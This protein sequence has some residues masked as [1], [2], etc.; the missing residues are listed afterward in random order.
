VGTLNAPFQSPKTKWQ[1]VASKPAQRG[2]AKGTTVWYYQ[3]LQM[4]E[5]AA[6]EA[7]IAAHGGHWRQRDVIGVS[8]Y[9]IK[10]Q[11][12][13]V[14]DIIIMLEA[15]KTAM[16]RRMPRYRGSCGA[17]TD[18]YRRTLKVAVAAANAAT[19]MLWETMQSR[20]RDVAHD[21]VAEFSQMWEMQSRTGD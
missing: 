3:S 6:T 21:A 15:M 16:F 11:G 18:N 12:F 13:N 17:M 20:T 14:D 2:H 4:F 7:G 8:E 5:Q 10:W 19:R 9:M 1:K